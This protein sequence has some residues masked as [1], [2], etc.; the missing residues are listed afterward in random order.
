MMRTQIFHSGR[1]LAALLFALLLLGFPSLLAAD[2]GA[3]VSVHGHSGHIEY[4]DRV[5]SER[6][7][8][9]WGLDFEQSSGLWNWIHYSIPVPW[10]TRARY[11]GVHFETGSIDAFISDLHVYDGGS[12]IYS[13]TGVNL[14]EGPSWYVLDMGE[15]KLIDE[16]LGLSIRVAAGVEMMSHRIIIYAVAA[17]W[18]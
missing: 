13:E 15:E 5:M 11:L 16:A 8:L 9:G 12:K 17:D 14:S 2:F 18:R 1:R 3:I 7:F 10:G 4:P 6:E